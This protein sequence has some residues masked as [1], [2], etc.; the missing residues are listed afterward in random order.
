MRGGAAVSFLSLLGGIT[1]ALVPLD[2][3]SRGML[4]GV[5][6]LACIVGLTLLV[7]GIR[8][9]LNQDVSKQL[10]DIDFSRWEGAR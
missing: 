6:A 8:D 9:V 3:L 7:F 4:L 2:P 5:A 1:G 10:A